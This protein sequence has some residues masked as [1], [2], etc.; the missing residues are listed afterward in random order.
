M[1]NGRAPR[2]FGV[3]SAR[4]AGGLAVLVWAACA[5][6]PARAQVGH[7]PA[8]SPFRDVTT[9]QELT[10]LGGWFNG[11]PGEANVGARPGSMIGLRLATRLSGPLDLVATFAG[12]NSSRYVVNPDSPVTSRTTGPIDYN[13]VIADL[14]LGF[15]L[16]GR[17][18]WR[19]HAPYIGLGIG[20]EIP[21]NGTTDP[22]GYVAK[23]NFTFIPA[24]G[25]RFLMG[26]SFAVQLEVRDHFIRY[27]YPL[28][29][30]QPNNPT[31]PPVLDPKRYD[32]KDMT[33]N[34]SFSLGLTYRFNF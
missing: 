5:A 14:G 7:D 13:L 6:L 4:L 17:K 15:N 12:I 30:F 27:E 25:T 20:I 8:S 23:Q 21:T 28:R 33:S 9:R 1:S 3:P 29:Y 16:T 24:F 26:R 31:V 19:G 22:G 2:P 18:T 34:W 11:N 10:V 32:E